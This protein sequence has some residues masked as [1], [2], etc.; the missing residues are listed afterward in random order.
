MTEPE[1]AKLTLVE[2]VD[3]PHCVD[4]ADGQRVNKIISDRLE[5]NHRVDLSFAGV[6]R[7]TTAFLNAAIGQ[8]YNEFSDDKIRT[9]IRFTDVPQGSADA[10]TKVV[11]RA[12]RFFSNPDA[13]RVALEKATG[14]E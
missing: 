10:I 13:A 3:S 6:E 14:R 11:A 1:V 4:T 7:I 9:S 5:H 2:I 12:K 8:L